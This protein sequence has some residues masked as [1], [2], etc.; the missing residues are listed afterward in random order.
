M[1]VI[2]VVS[3]KTYVGNDGK[4]HHYVNF[5]LQCNNGKRIAIKCVN[6]E[7]YSRLDMV[8]TY[9]KQ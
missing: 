3:K 1:E 7:D 5:Y 2:K 9:V 6:K 4:E 8:A